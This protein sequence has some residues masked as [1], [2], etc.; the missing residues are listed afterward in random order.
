MFTYW[1][2]FVQVVIFIVSISVYG[3]AP[4]GFDETTVS[5]EI[6]QPNLALK[7]ES[8]RVKENLWIGPR[9]V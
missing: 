9:Q 4:I 1:M 2:T 6:I 5:K 3:V 8:Y 7:L